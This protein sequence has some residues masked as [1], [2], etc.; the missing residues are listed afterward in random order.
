MTDSCTTTTKK[1]GQKPLGKT[2]MFRAGKIK[3][4]PEIATLTI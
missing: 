1:K 2:L 3:L 4:C